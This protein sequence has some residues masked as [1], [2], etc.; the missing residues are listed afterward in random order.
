LE[1]KV[2][3]I[4]QVDREVIGL[5][6]SELQDFEEIRIMILPDHPTP[7]SLRTHTSDAVPYMIYDKKH[8]LADSVGKY[9]EDSALQGR[10]FDEGWKLMDYFIKD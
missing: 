4:E 5:I 1:T 3:A 9:D 10:F 7:I 2:W 8:P 6:I